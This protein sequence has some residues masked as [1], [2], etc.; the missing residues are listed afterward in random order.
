MKILENITF[1]KWLSGVMAL[2]V[3]FCV[4]DLAR[5]KHRKQLLNE[6][7]YNGIQVFTDD[8]TGCQYLTGL[9]QGITPRISADGEHVGCG[10]RIS[11]N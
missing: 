6:E 1:L 7:A 10:Q 8:V 11:R 4:V 2:Y 9:N 5:D 3:I